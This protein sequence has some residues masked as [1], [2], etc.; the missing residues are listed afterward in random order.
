MKPDT[1]LSGFFFYNLGKKEGSYEFFT[2][3]TLRTE[4]VCRAFT[5]DHQCFGNDGTKADSGTVGSILAARYERS[6][7][8]G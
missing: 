6:I 7:L 2:Y 4:T 3:D 1:L 5:T 8:A